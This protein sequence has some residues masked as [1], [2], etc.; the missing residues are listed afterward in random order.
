MLFNYNINTSINFLNNFN[1]NFVLNNIKNKNKTKTRLLLYFKKIEYNYFLLVISLQTKKQYIKQ[2]QWSTRFT[3]PLFRQ[4]RARTMS[5]WCLPITIL[6]RCLTLILF[7]TW[8]RA[9]AKPSFISKSGLLLQKQ[10]SCMMILWTRMLRHSSSI[11]NR[12]SFGRCWWLQI[13]RKRYT[14]RTTRI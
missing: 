1:I 10:R 3:F 4:A 14:I 13:R 11:V 6:A 2:T 5:R 9:G 12:E 8:W 7:K